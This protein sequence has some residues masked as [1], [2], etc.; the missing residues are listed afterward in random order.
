MTMKANERYEEIENSTWI[1]ERRLLGRPKHGIL[2][3]TDKKE[4]EAFIVCSVPRYT[5]FSSLIKDFD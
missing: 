3:I 4:V 1:T 5:S 2:L